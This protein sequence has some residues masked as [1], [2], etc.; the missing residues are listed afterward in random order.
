[1]HSTQ[2]QKES[3]FVPAQ[4]AGSPTSPVSEPRHR[5]ARF[6]PGTCCLLMTQQL[7]PTPRRNSSHWW[8]ASHRP[9][10]TSDW[11]SIWRRRMS[12]DRTHKHR[13]SLPSTT[14]DSILSA[15][16][17]TSAPPSLTTSHWTHISTRGLARQRQ[18]SSVSLLEC[19]Q[20]PICL[21]RESLCYQH[22]AVWQREPPAAIT[23]EIKLSA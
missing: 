14:M 22:I 8:T 7:R 23:C 10:R 19:G 13:R 21:R 5:Y 9:V 17:P 1:M 2:Q 3:T 15:S 6:S 20:A 11:P 12:W 16:P 18:L 4:M